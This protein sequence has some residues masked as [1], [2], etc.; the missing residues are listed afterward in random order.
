[1]K[2]LN[3]VDFFHQG[4]AFLPSNEPEIGDVLLV[5]GK[6]GECEQIRISP[7]SYLQQLARLFGV[8]LAFLRERYGSVIGKKQMIPLPLAPNWTL[9]PVQVRVPIGKQQAHG[10]IVKQAIERI[11]EGKSIQLKGD[12]QVPLLHSYE[13]MRR[14]LRESQ[15]VEL[16][17]NLLHQ[18]PG[19][20]KESKEKYLYMS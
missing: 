18:T 1:M 3:V 20:V 12:H 10:W 17:F 5:Y 6:N 8:D 19:W 14:I 2:S 16:H 7:R 13:D 9:M 15:L 4:V 11:D